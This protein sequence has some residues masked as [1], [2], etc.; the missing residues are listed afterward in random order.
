M[1]VS[2]EGI[3]HGI[4]AIDFNGE[5]NDLLVQVFDYQRKEVR[6]ALFMGPYPYGTQPDLYLEVPVRGISRTVLRDYFAGDLNGDGK[7]DVLIGNAWKV[8]STH[9][10][11]AWDVFLGTSDLTTIL[12]SFTLRND[13]G[14]YF[15]KFS[16]AIADINKDG[17]DD[18]LASHVEGYYGR[19]KLFYGKSNI[20]EIEPSDSLFN[21]DATIYKWMR[22]VSPVGDLNGD[23]TRDILVG[24]V[25][26]LFPTATVFHCYPNRSSDL[27]M[28]SAGSFGI[29]G[30]YEYVDVT[31]AFPAGDVNNDGYDDVLLLGRSTVKNSLDPGNGFKI[32]GGSEKL[33]GVRPVASIP[34]KMRLTAYPNP[35][36]TTDGRIVLELHAPSPQEGRI[37]IVDILG[38]VIC[39]QRID[40]AHGLLPVDLSAHSLSPGRYICRFLTSESAVSTVL[41]VL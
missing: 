27:H 17:C 33:V 16:P 36:P 8:D 5:N 10:I 24:W 26:S 9:G 3:F 7:T 20:T 39:D 21:P 14:W 6:Y 31:R 37:E 28:H 12:P 23:G 25:L 38:N 40:D 19:V 1:G 4:D 2:G 41:I 34:R 32:Y 30:D 11:A 35:A 29:D 13:S 18:I 22:S 15:E